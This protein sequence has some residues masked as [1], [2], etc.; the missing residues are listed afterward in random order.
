MDFEEECK[1]HGGNFVPAPDTHPD[2]FDRV[3]A[4]YID[5]KQKFYDM[6]D[7]KGWHDGKVI[8]HHH[9]PDEHINYEYSRDKY[10]NHRIFL[11]EM[12]SIPRKEKVD[13]ATIVSKVVT[14]KGKPFLTTRIESYTDDIR[15][16]EQLMERRKI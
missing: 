16:V 11:S 6:V 13:G 4:C 10:G 5:D 15:K 14:F 1:K 7:D 3:D 9:T 12:Y 8:Y 2:I